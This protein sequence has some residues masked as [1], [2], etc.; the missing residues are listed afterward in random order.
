MRGLLPGGPGVNLSVQAAP[1]AYSMP[2]PAMAPGMAMGI[3]PMGGPD[4]KEWTL[5]FGG[6]VVIENGRALLYDSTQNASKPPAPTTITGLR[7][8]PGQDVVNRFQIDGSV[9]ILLYVADPALPRARVR[10][11]DL[12]RHG[13]RPL[14]LAC[15]E[16]QLVRVELRDSAG[17]LAGGME[18]VVEIRW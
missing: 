14:N 11:A 1:E 18:V 9:E 3:G 12:L 16:N 13:E 8:Q 5:L 10:L 7:V 4:P 17:M 2:Q 15:G 6:Q